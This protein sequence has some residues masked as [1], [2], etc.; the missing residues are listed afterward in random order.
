MLPELNIMSI[1]WSIYICSSVKHC[2][3]LVIDFYWGSFE[4]RKQLNNRHKSDL[5]QNKTGIVLRH[6][7]GPVRANLP[8]VTFMV[9]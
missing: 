3:T 6:A 1:L 2:V 7:S 4:A 5:I 9:T 8:P